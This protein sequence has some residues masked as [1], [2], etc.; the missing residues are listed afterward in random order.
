MTEDIAAECETLAT[1]L[2][3]LGK[4]KS[5]VGWMFGSDRVKGRTT[6][7]IGDERVYATGL[8]V[9]M[10]GDIA[11]S[12]VILMRA[13]HTYTA[14]SLTRT[15]IEC[16][17]LLAY[18]AQDPEVAR[19]WLNADGPTRRTY[20]SPQKLRN[21]LPG[22]FRD[23]EYWSHSDS[24]HPTP[25]ALHFLPGHSTAE[26]IEQWWEELRLH[27]RRLSERCDQVVRVLDLT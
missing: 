24:S 20:W 19:E 12:A 25:F 6:H 16:E 15:L 4:Q 26:P 5:I 23:T 13:G 1:R 9:E 17:Y 7:G 18:F 14:Q 21:R 27:L 8:V 10:A 3:A 11:E 22:M 2:T